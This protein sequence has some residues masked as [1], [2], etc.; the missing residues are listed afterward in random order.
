MKNYFIV[1][2]SYLA[3]IIGIAIYNFLGLGWIGESK[4]QE[5]RYAKIGNVSAI[6]NLIVAAFL[7]I[8]LIIYSISACCKTNNSLFA[9]PKV[10]SIRKP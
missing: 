3:Y 9:K 2:L 6:L 1:L 8:V 4:C 7:L 5:T 10:F